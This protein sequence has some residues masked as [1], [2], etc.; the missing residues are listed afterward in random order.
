MKLQRYLS[1]LTAA[2]IVA[3]VSPVAMAHCQI[4]C[5]IYD[6]DA[7]FTLMRE[8]VTTLEKSI[9]EINELQGAKKPNWNQLVRWVENKEDHAD[10]L[11]EIVT[12]YFMA[13]RIKPPKDGKDSAAKEKYQREIGMLHRMLIATMKTKQNSDLTHTQTLRNL[14]R[15]FEESYH[16]HGHGR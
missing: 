10:A 7:R 14:I 4:P 5:G 9:R 13:Q 8:H 15:R 12:Y 16:G 3:A 11:A 6:D 1:V 2:M